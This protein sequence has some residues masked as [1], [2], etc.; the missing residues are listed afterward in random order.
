MKKFTKHE[1]ISPREMQVKYYTKNLQVH[2]I[3]T[4]VK[5]LRYFI[6]IKVVSDFDMFQCGLEVVTVKKSCRA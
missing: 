4:L 5:I 3:A 1:F 6:A 2:L